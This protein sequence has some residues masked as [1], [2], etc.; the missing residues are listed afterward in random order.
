MRAREGQA[1]K[2]AEH[3]AERAG[4]L[5]V[6]TGLGEMRG[7][8]RRNWACPG[9]IYLAALF[10]GGFDRDCDGFLALAQESVHINARGGYGRRAA[11][12]RR[13]CS[14]CAASANIAARR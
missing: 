14:V 2:R 3:H 9:R 5:T 7:R 8:R 1:A 6:G 10:G 11:T 4:R 12:A 13:A